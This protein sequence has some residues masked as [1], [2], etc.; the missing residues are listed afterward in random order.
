[1]SRQEDSHRGNGAPVRHGAF[2]ARSEDVGAGYELQGARSG[3]S[4]RC[5]REFLRV[6]HGGEPVADHHRQRHAGRG[7][8][9][10]ADEMSTSLPF[11]VNFLLRLALAY[12]LTLAT[13]AFAE[14]PSVMSVAAVGMTVSDMDRSVAFYSDVLT[15]KK[16][17]D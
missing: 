6:E 8:L 9:V 14:Q 12:G 10:G 13:A 11:R 1:L 16:I 7:S 5:G 3:Q 2:R 17:S 15:F 4:L